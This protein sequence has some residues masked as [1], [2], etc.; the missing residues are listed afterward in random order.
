M[1]YNDRAD[2]NVLQCEVLEQIEQE[3]GA[4]DFVNNIVNI[5]ERESRVHIEE[6]KKACRLKD[7]SVIN[8]LSHTL[9]SNSFNLGGEKVGQLCQDLE[10]YS[11]KGEAISWDEV[12][13]SIQ[14]IE[15]CYETL[16]ELILKKVS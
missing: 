2:L 12:M 13:S 7:E 8:H 3:S 9:A 6:L 1:N 5:Y 16:I 10:R 14:R 15:V 4:T 11:M